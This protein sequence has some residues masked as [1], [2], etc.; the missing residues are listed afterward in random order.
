[1][2]VIIEPT[3]DEEGSYTIPAYT[4]LKSNSRSV[5]VGLRNMSCRTVSLNK[6]TVVAELSPANAIPKMLAPK[7]AS[8]QL[9]FAKNQ[10]L[11]SNELEFA[12]S[13]NSQPKL[14]KE[15]RDKIFSKLDLT[16]YDNWTQDQRESMNATIECYHHIFA[17]EDLE[18]GRTNLVKHEIKLTNYVPF[19]ERYRRIPPHQYEEVRKHLDKMLRMGQL[20]DLIVRGRVQWYLSAKKMVL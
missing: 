2:N 19:K 9:E 12:N 4:Y 3:D 17:V 11:E 18:L 1:M 16:G 20:E 7:L 8:C 6:G 13:T 5:H 15:R 10:G 14:T